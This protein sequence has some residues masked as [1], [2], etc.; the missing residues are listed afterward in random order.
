MPGPSSKRGVSDMRVSHL[1]VSPM[2][3]ASTADR[4]E[5]PISIKPAPFP[6]ESD[7]DQSR[8]YDRRAALASIDAPMPH[9]AARVAV[10][11]RMIRE[12]GA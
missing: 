12:L 2:P 6:L 1:I 8:P 7:R 11:K 10:V 3:A 9:G 4:A 5:Y